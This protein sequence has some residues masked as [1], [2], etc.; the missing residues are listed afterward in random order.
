MSS[1]WDQSGGADASP[2]A[3]AAAAAAA[4]AKIAA[5]LGKAAPGATAS[6]S[7]ANASPSG[8]EGGAGSGS[9]GGERASQHHAAFMAKIE[10]ND[11]RNRYMLTKTATLSQLH[12]ETGASVS[13]KGRWYPDKSM[14]TEENP[15]LYLEIQA[16]TQEA[17]DKAKEA[18]EELMKQDVPQLIVDRAAQRAAWENQRPGPGALSGPVSG[19]GGPPGM[20][21]GGPGTGVNGQ[22]QDGGWGNRRKWNE[23]K[24]AIGLESLRN[25]NIR[26]KVVGPGGLFVKYIQQETGCR[27][28]IKG[29]GS[30]FIEHETGRE[31]EEQMFIHI[32]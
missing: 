28:Q 16:A 5:S 32:T 6:P 7:N 12:S 8:N 30:G 2:G 13:P 25:F 27:I 23:E 3:A 20:G 4:A 14:A 9:G 19:A 24:V 22:A 26:A 11:Q 31:A 17:L 29:L 18:I 15:P 10:I 21:A 1:R